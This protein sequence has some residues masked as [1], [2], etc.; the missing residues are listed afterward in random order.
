MLVCN[1][2]GDA[3]IAWLHYDRKGTKKLCA[4]D[5]ENLG[6]AEKSG[7]PG[8]MSTGHSQKEGAGAH[9]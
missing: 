5:H 3:G 7:Q 8:G 6:V 2:A 4:I 1:A 9:A